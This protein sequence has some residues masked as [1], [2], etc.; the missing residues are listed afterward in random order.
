M[1]RALILVFGVEQEIFQA[2]SYSPCHCTNNSSRIECESS[3]DQVEYLLEDALTRS[4]LCHKVS[5]Y[6]VSLDTLNQN[7][8]AS[9]TS[10]IPLHHSG[11]QVEA[12]VYY[13]DL[14]LDWGL[15]CR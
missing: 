15:I 14:D 10:P 11:E 1:L 7:Y 4:S 5:R 12:V 8:E 2:C 3:M 13:H 9:V 6:Q